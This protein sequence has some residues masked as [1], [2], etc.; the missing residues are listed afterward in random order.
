MLAAADELIH[1]SNGDPRWRDSVYWNFSDP[2]REIG[3]WIYLWTLPEQPEPFGMIVSFYHGGWPD[4]DIY[5]K[6]MSQLGHRLEQGGRWIYCYQANGRTARG[7]DFD[8][9]EI[10]GL[11]IRRIEPMARYELSFADDCG[12]GFRL[13][14]NYLTPPFDYADGVHATP[15]WLATNRYHRSHRVIGE[16][17]IGGSR[18]AI[19]CSGDSDHSWGA[20]DWTI[21]ARNPFKMWSFQTADGALAASFMEQGTDSGPLPLGY[22]SIGGVMSSVKSIESAAV[23]DG[24]GVQ[25][26]IEVVVE[27]AAGR[28][29][30]AHCPRM[31]SHVGWGQAGE[32]WGY[33]GVGAYRVEG[34]GDVPGASSYFWPGRVRPDSLQAHAVPTDLPA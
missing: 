30:R 11:R 21:F 24:N 19:D 29:L 23:Y 22:V 14:S 8:D 6:A 20:R 31:H 2:A 34:H 10:A 5:A 12:N 15:E 3:A 4:P 17:T 18:M 25:S 16:L 27:D 33:E 9:L 32:F 1:A 7:S 13:E 28:R 26:Q